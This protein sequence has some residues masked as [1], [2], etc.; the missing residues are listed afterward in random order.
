MARH[1]DECLPGTRTDILDQIREWAVSPQG[2]CIFWLNGMAGTGKSTISR[3]V[4]KSLR[5]DKSLGASFF[6]KRGEGDRGNAMKLFPTVARQ[7]ALCIPEMITSVQKAV[8]DD[9]D[10]AMKGMKEQ[11]DKLL[12]QP[13][14]CLKGSGR[15]IRTV[16]IVIDALDECDEDKDMRLIL[17]LLPQLHKLKALHLRVFLTSRPETPIRLGFKKLANRDYEDLVLHEIREEL[18]EHDISLYLNHRLSEVRTDRESPLPTD[19]PGSMNVQKL[20]ALSIPLFIF[21]ATICRIL[22]DPYWDPVD[23]LAKILTYQNHGSKLDGTYLPVLDRLLNTQSEEQKLQLVQEFHHVVGTIVILESPLSVISLSRLLGCSRE[24][25]CL[26][27]KP[28]HS[29]LN[30]PS[31][32][33]LPVRLFHVS[34]RDFLLDPETRKKTPL[35]VDEKEIHR[36]L[37]KQCLNVCASLR[38]NICGLPSDGTEHAKIARQTID[39]F[40]PPELQYACRYWA[41]HLAQCI[42]L[43]DVIRDALLFLRRQFLHWVEAMSLLGLVSEVVGMLNLLWAVISVSSAAAIYD[44]H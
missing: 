23:S 17:Q 35:W 40:L 27:L 10:I 43:N 18:I 29:I 33:V 41:N 19:W 20:V 3:T 42:D 25:V 11:F 16:V 9:L 21:A 7:I 8:D 39:H 2:K 31:D 6:F 28:L 37:A 24:L 13:L 44:S 34:F 15:P 22:E 5:Q 1:E 38:R 26:R 12:F 30:V 14:L 32:D 36:R 4:A